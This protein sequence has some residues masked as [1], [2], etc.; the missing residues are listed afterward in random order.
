MSEE[1]NYF[2]K[3]LKELRTEKG[4]TLTSLG[5]DIGYS[6]PYLSQIENG[7]KGIPSPEF[8]RK[9]SDALDVD[10]EYLLY[11]SGIIDNDLYQHKLQLEESHKKTDMEIHQLETELERIL[12]EYI[13][14]Q[15]SYNE[16]NKSSSG[17]EEDNK[18]LSQKSAQKEYQKI[19][20]QEILRSKR[21]INQDLNEELNRLDELIKQE[22][23]D[24]KVEN[25]K[26]VESQ[27][28]SII[29]SFLDL[30]GENA[31]EMAGINLPDFYDDDDAPDIRDFLNN[32]I[33]Y[34]DGKLLDY[35]NKNLA[36]KILDVLF[37]D[38][39]K[40]YPEDEEIEENTNKQNSIDTKN[41]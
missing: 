5:N 20:L 13:V 8:L 12:R 36:I 25:E 16:N 10:Y 28:N 38:V 37:E 11:I 4:Y 33:V 29:D 17:T 22:S 7:K 3:K 21:M 30:F 41:D 14:I 39:E 9:I 19:K 26:E 35:K 31:D 15:H 24:K 34:Y 40:N 1:D 2:G 32:H 27:K 23:I 18:I 6:N